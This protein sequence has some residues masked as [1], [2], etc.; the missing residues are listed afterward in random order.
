MDAISK[1]ML[2]NT[3]AQIFQLVGV[4]TLMAIKQ[5]HTPMKDIFDNW[6]D[7]QYNQTYFKAM[8][9]VAD[10]MYIGKEVATDTLG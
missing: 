9:M 1:A 7:D 3:P 6:M 8:T 5:G 10:K 4:Q 2:V